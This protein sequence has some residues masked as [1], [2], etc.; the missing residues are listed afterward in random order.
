MNVQFCG[1][2]TQTPA[3]CLLIKLEIHLGWLPPVTPTRM[4][5]A[6]QADARPPVGHVRG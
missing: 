6:A 4:S 5:V 2:K 3:K 1:G